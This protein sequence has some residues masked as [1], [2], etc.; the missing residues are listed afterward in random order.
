MKISVVTI[1]FNQVEFLQDCIDSVAV[2]DGPYEHIIVDPGSTDGSRQLIEANRS[3]FTEVVFEKDDNPADGLNKGF[4]KASGDIFYY[5]NSDDIVFPGAFREALRFLEKNETVDVLAGSGLILDRDGRKLRRI[6]SD[7]VSKM[8]LAYGS[9]ILI[10][11]ATF[12]R[13]K[14]FEKVGGFNLENNSNW[15]GE[16]VVDLF[17]SGAEFMI[18]RNIWGGYRLHEESITSTGRTIESIRKW[19]GRKRSKL[20]VSQNPIIVRVMANFYRFERLARE[21]FRIMERIAKG[22]VFGRGS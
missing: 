14:S 4:S 7:A 12:I 20:G 17:R 1:C 21:P 15:D 10:Q 18:V 9:G 3:R 22:R 19:N 13:K 8:R 16:L 5:L 11:P 2:Q 6:T